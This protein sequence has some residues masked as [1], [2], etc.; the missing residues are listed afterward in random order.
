MLVKLGQGISRGRDFI[1]VGE[2]LVG[3]LRQIKVLGRVEEVLM[4]MGKRVMEKRVMEKMDIMTPLR[5]CRIVLLGMS[6]IKMRKPLIKRRKVRT[7]R[8]AWSTKTPRATKT[9]RTPRISRTAK[10]M[11]TSKTPTPTLPFTRCLP[12]PQPTPAPSPRENLPKNQ[13]KFKRFGA[14]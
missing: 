4:R 1:R 12:D 3:F 5:R 7:T 14:Q 8:T 13:P 2:M 11:R 10:N 6:K 9:P